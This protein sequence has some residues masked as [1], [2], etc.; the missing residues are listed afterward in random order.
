[1]MWPP[2]SV[3]S[4]SGEA[5]IDDIARQHADFAAFI[6][7]EGDLAEVHVVQF[8]VERDRI[9]TDGGNGS[10]LCLVGIEIRGREDNR[11]ARLPFTG[12]SRLRSMLLPASAV[13]DSL[14]QE[15]FP[16]RAGSGFRP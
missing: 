2:K 10:L 8:L 1:M 3:W 4:A 6:H 15:F 5:W 13:L 9:A 14:V 12:D 16:Y 11:L 7:V